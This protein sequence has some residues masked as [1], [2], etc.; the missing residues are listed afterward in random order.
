[1]PLIFSARTDIRKTVETLSI[2][3]IGGLVFYGAA[4]PGGLISGAMI[5]VG[6][7]GMLGRPVGLRSCD[8]IL[9]AHQHQDAEHDGED[10]IAAVVHGLGFRGPSGR[11]RLG[12]LV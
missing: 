9:P 12:L 8:E 2:G 10:H 5:A 6:A 1:M 11:W 3:I 7:A 4:L